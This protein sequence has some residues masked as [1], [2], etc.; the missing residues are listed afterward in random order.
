MVEVPDPDP[1]AWR[2]RIAELERA[3][4]RRSRQLVLLL[5]RLPPELYG[6]AREILEGDPVTPRFA[7]PPE[8]WEESIELVPVEV[9]EAL[10]DLWAA[11]PPPQPPPR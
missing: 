8:R 1:E 7:H 10:A 5:D 3:L 11:T 6:V 4:R 2:A 9:E